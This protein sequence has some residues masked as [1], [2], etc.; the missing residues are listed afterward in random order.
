MAM[1][2]ATQDFKVVIVDHSLV[3]GTKL[4]VLLSPLTRN[5]TLCSSYNQALQVVQSAGGRPFDCLFYALP[6]SAHPEYD[7]AV[8][9]LLS[10]LENRLA[11]RTIIVMKGE[12]PQ[13]IKAL[14]PTD[15]CVLRKPLTRLT[16]KEA[17]ADLSQQSAKTNCWEYKRCGR[18]PGG[19]HA[20]ELGICPAAEHQATNG[21]HGGKNGGRVCWA[22]SGTFCGGMIKGTFAEDIINCV[23]CDFFKLV[24]CEEEEL[25]ESIE[26]IF[27]RIREFY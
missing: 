10:V 1:V 26:S 27:R 4:M 6:S 11:L 15:T 23:D 5:L 17:L 14:A 24:Q 8:A 16:I 20:A 3:D 13:Q 21:I 19:R 25:F 18:E 2:S 9:A 12:L 22:I 7:L